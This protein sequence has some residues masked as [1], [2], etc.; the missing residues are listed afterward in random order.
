[1]MK[2]THI[3][4]S[5]CLYPNI[6]VEMIQFIERCI[7]DCNSV[8][9]VPDA[10]YDGMMEQY[11]EL[12]GKDIKSMGFTPPLSVPNLFLGNKGIEALQRLFR[13]MIN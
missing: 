4:N 3:I 11:C 1:M 10:I 2:Q 7:N 13:G 12:I 9:I 8:L 6:S 5:S